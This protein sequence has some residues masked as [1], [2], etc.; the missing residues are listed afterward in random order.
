MFDPKVK[1]NKDVFQKVKVAATTLGVTVEEFCEKVLTTEANNIIMRGSNSGGKKEVSAEEAEQIAN[2][3][4][5]LGYL[6]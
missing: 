3:L 1:L 2:Q 6:E 5:G 4:K